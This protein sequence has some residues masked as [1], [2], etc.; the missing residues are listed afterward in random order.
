MIDLGDRRDGR[1]LSALAEPLLDGDGGRN[2]GE[3][4]DVRLRHDLKKLPRVSG[5]AVDVTALAFRVDDIEGQRGLS[6]PAQAGDDHEAISGDVEADIFKIV[7]FGADY[8]NGVLIF[9]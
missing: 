3:Q 6:G 8:G 2:A 7:L 4:I 5:K 9:S 1:I